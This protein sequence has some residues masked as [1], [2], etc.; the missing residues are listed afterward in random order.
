MP[1]IPKQNKSISMNVSVTGQS[2]VKRHPAALFSDL[3]GEIVLLQIEAG[4]Y[5]GLEEVG[6]FIWQQLQIPRRMGDLRDSIQAEY[7]VDCG[8]CEADLVYFL[9]DLAKRQLI[10]I[11]P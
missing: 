10:E 5:F 6:A 2:V 4:I 1:D 9:E 7:E 11:L 8:K 3:Q